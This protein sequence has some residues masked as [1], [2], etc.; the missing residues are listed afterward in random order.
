MTE[1]LCFLFGMM[2]GTAL[3]SWWH[4]LNQRLDQPLAVDDLGCHVCRQ[5]PCECG[6][7]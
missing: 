7:Q 2:A 1:L 3:A 5:Q 6:E 4:D